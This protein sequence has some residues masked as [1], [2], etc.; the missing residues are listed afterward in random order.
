MVKKRFLWSHG[1]LEF[2]HDQLFIK[3]LELDGNVWFIIESVCEWF[4]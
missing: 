4:A 3:V 2:F 1:K